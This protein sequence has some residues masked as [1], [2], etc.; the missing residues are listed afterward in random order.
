VLAPARVLHTC[1]AHRIVSPMDLIQ[2]L[3]AHSIGEILWGI[4]GNLLGLLGFLLGAAFLFVVLPI[5]VIVAAVVGVRYLIKE[6]DKAE[7]ERKLGEQMRAEIQELYRQA[8]V[9]FTSPDEFVRILAAALVLEL[10]RQKIAVPPRD[11]FAELLKA[12]TEIYK[13]E[14]PARAPPPLEQISSPEEIRPFAQRAAKFDGKVL[15]QAIVASLVAFLKDL[16]ESRQ[17]QFAVPV[18]DVMNERQAIIDVMMPFYHTADIADRDL[19]RSIRFTYHQGAKTAAGKQKSKEELVWPLEYEGEHA[20]AIYLAPVLAGL[21]DWKVPWGLS[22]E[23]RYMHHWCLGSFGSGKTTYLSHFILHDLARVAAGECSLIVMDSQRLVRQVSRLKDFAP[24]GPLHDRVIIID[25]DPDYAL[26]LN[27]FQLKSSGRRERDINATVDILTYALGGTETTTFQKD[28]MGFVIEAAAS[29]P[30]AN[31]NTLLKFFETP[32]GGWVFPF[33]EVYDQLSEVVRHYFDA[34]FARLPTVTKDGIHTRIMNLRRHSALDRMLNA[35]T[36][37]LDLF[38]E[39]QQGG[40]VILI[41]T[42]LDTLNADGTQIFGRLLIAMIDQ[43]ATKRA[44]FDEKSLRPVFVIIDEAHDYI[45]FDNRFGDL[46]VKARNK[47]VGLTRISHTIFAQ[48]MGRWGAVDRLLRGHAGSWRRGDASEAGDFC[49]CCGGSEEW[50]LGGS[51]VM[52][53]CGASGSACQAGPARARAVR[54]SLTAAVP[55]I[56]ALGQA[57]AMAMRMRRTL[58]RTRAPI[59]SS[60]RRMVPQVASARSVSCRPMRRSAQSRT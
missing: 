9:K 26:A 13:D 31:L 48:S 5:G 14:L 43:L 23:T 29:V 17:A 4:F 25:P 12:G 32:R 42:D 50:S 16:P 8:S 55:Q 59:L 28:A 18:R 40:K 39:L 37:E 20:S 10:E 41:D 51:G 27:P 2:P 30:R 15:T 53:R 34:T 33:P 1:H 11:L 19:C 22:D 56:C 46:V 6:A 38:N 52:P 47:R 45:R 35:P 7:A 54:A 44:R 58:M 57:E 60:L 3:A 21:F 49:W 36:C 24:G